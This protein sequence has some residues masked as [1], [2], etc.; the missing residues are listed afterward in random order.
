[1]APIEH[2]AQR[3]VWS[4]EAFERYWASPGDPV[5]AMGVIWP[6]IAGY[7]PRARRPLVGAKAYVQGLRDLIAAAPKRIAE[8]YQAWLPIAIRPLPVRFPDFHLALVWHGRAHT[9]P[10]LAWLRALIGESAGEL[11][12]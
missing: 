10:C 12:A 8:I 7:W 5:V 6:G 11:P 9:D 1:M 2:A 3:R 4:V